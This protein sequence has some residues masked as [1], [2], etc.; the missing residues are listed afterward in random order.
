M[1]FDESK[2]MSHFDNDKEMIGELL[3]V[4]ES[5][6]EETL[7]ELKSALSE[8]NFKNVELHAHTLKGMIANFFSDDL[9]ESAYQLELSGKNE[10][11]EG[12]ASHIENLESKLP[13]LVSEIEE[14]CHG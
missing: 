3:E 12:H 10:N 5:T 14:M 9:K 1:L 4:F 7:G 8:S 6:Y 11:I 2:L 13:Q